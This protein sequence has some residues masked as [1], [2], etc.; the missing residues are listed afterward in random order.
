MDMDVPSYKRLAADLRGRIRS[1]E[2]LPGDR[3]PSEERLGGEMGLSRTTIRK[4]I[5]VL[6]AE[7]W[8]EVRAPAGV[9]VRG[10][11]VVMLTAG[12]EVVVQDGAMLLWRA[13]GEVLVL[14]AGT[15][16]R[17]GPAWY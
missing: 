14:S 15:V 3:M 6:R 16:L 11:E 2:L 4:A 5:D 7:G 1:G 17:V 13:D 10:R 12:D 9:F 8:V